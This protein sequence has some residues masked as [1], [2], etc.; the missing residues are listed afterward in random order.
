MKHMTRSYPPENAMLRP[1]K[2]TTLEKQQ[3]KRQDHNPPLELDDSNILNR[4]ANER[5]RRKEALSKAMNKYH[6]VDIVG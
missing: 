5:M 4:K 3:K 2:E 1:H 6:D